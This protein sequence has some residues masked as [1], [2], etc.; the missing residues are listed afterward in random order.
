MSR[1]YLV[2][3]EAAAHERL[4]RARQR[5]GSPTMDQFILL[6]LALAERQAGA[7]QDDG[8]I[9]VIDGDPDDET[10]PILAVRVRPRS[11]QAGS[12]ADEHAPA[13]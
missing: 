5:Y 9:N 6:A 2:T 1:Q 10:A 3:L 8:V 11:P 7:I 12:A 4:E 13:I